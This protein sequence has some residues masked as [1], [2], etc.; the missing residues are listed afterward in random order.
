MEVTILHITFGLRS[1]YE[2][3]NYYGHAGNRIE[4]DVR[5]MRRGTRRRWCKRKG[6]RRR[7]GEI[8]RRR[9]R[10]RRRSR[11]SR[12]R[13]RRRKRRKKRRKRRRRRRRRRR[14][15]RSRRRR[16]RRKKMR[17]RRRRRRGRRRKRRR[18]TLWEEHLIVKLGRL[19]SESACEREDPGSNPAADMVDAARNTAWDLDKQLNNY[20]SNYPTQEWARRR[21]NKPRQLKSRVNS[22]S[23]NFRLFYTGPQLP[24]AKHGGGVS[25]QNTPLRD[26]PDQPLAELHISIDR[27]SLLL[28]HSLQCGLVSCLHLLTLSVIVTRTRSMGLSSAVL[29]HVVMEDPDTGSL[30]SLN[31]V[32]NHC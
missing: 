31:S 28:D 2:P 14:S 32:I 11:R 26:G 30:E 20:R 27:L 13:K 16:R 12:R 9:R 1:K 25:F 4:S 29:G 17:K 10:R 19:V 18:R 7:K 23:R 8:R 15:R 5:S 21:S 22:T 24:V 6:K 3:D